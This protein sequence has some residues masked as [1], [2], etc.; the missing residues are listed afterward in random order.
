[1]SYS[2]NLEEGF[3]L[4]ACPGPTG[5][6]LD[7]GA[8]NPFDK[9][10]TRALFERGWGGVMVEPSPGPFATL[11]A[12]YGDGLCGNATVKRI[13]LIQAAVVLDPC[14]A[15]VEMY[16]TDDAVS[17][18]ELANYEKW[19][20]AAKF[21]GQIKVKAITLESIFQEYGDFDFVSLDAEG[22]SV[23]LMHRVFALGRLPKCIC[24][25]HDDRTD[26]VLAAAIG[27]GYA[28]AY[29]NGENL[30]LVR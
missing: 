6:F 19:K 4:A 29:A 15:E 23:D 3:I 27:L 10:N 14:I 25:E 16:V 30:I 1:M 9:S 21:T 13:E 7:I 8:W 28:C 11:K 26:E 20:N 18:T 22:T 2:Q 5:W 17:T 12:E 24:V